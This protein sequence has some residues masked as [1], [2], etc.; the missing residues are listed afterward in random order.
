MIIGPLRKGIYIKRPNRFIVELETPENKVISIH[1]PNTGSMKSMLNPGCIAWYSESEN[2]NRKN[3]FTLEFMET[4]L[5]ALCGVNTNLPN[6]IVKEA[7]LTQKIPELSSYYQVKSEV[8]YGNNSRIDILMETPAGKVFIEVKNVT[9]IESSSVALFP[10]SITSRGTK[11]L[12]DLAQMVEEGHRS[13]IFYVVNRED[14]L[15]FDVAR[16]ID[17]VYSQAFE[18]AKSKGVEV[19][20]FGNRFR[21]SG[22]SVHLELGHRII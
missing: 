11:H 5:G 6:H 1:C 16:H 22:S 2:Q 18:Y 8:R 7:I 9:L 13:I 10:D 12:N 14:A 17:P 21:R 15:F 19:M 4:P 3:P 20:A